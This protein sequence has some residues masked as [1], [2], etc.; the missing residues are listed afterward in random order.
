MNSNLSLNT[1][2]TESGLA[3]TAK[4]LAPVEHGID[5]PAAS[6]GFSLPFDPL[7]VVDAIYARRWIILIAGII[8]GAGLVIAGMKRFSTHHA[9]VAQLI[10]QTPGST[11]RQSDSGDPYQP[12][13]L[14]IPTLMAVMRSAALMEKTTARLDGKFSEGLLKSGLIIT[15]ERNTDIV[16]VSMNSDESPDAAV[17]MLKGYV[18]EVLLLTRDIQQHDAAEANRFLTQQIELADKDLVKV[19]DEL[20]VYGKREQ[21][22]DADKQMDSYLGEIAGFNLKYEA[23]RLDHE[24]VDLKIKSIENELAKVSP[25][26]A[27]LQQ[28]RE[29]L[30]SLQLRYTNEHPSVL[31][32]TDRVK[33]MEATLGSDK[34]RLDAPP[35]QGDGNVSESLYLELVKLRSEKQVLGEQLGKLLAVRDSLSAKLEELPRKSLEYARIKSRKQALETSRNLLAAR[36]RE[37]AM[38]EE[39]AQGSFRLLAMARPQDVII[40][41][42]TK[43]LAM[44]GIGGFAGAAGGLA[45]LFGLLAAKDRRVVTVKDLKRSTGLPVLGSL[46]L[47]NEDQARDWAFHTWTK[48]QP[49]LL[50]PIPGGALIC[51]LITSDDDHS[52]RMPMLLANA[53]AS[54]GMSV[55]VVSRGE[56][57]PTS[58]PLREVV[59]QPESVLRS[60]NET[61]QL[62][63]HLTID[64][65]WQWNLTQRQQWQ[66]TM[67]QWAQARGTVILVQLTKPSQADTLLVAERLPNLL[68]IGQSE[69]QRAEEAATQ[70][71]TYRAAGCRIVG[72]LLDRAPTFRLGLLNKLAAT[73]ACLLLSMATLAHADDVVL[74]PGDAVN[75][76]AAGLPEL[77]RNQVYVGPDGNIT[78]LQAQNFRAAGLTID[79]LRVKLM[80]ELRRY[81]KNLLLVVTPMT[82]QSRKVYVLGKVVRKG[83]INMDRPLTLLEVVAEA[84]GLETGLFQQNT[85][86]LADLGRSFLMRGNQRMPVDMEKLFLRGDMS[87]NVPIKPD[88]Y[89]YF[90]SANSNEI[91]VLGDVTMQ[92]TQG[93]LAHTSV[94]S[95]IAQ[96]GGFTPK[97]YTRRILVVRGSLEK[98][99]TF[100]VN[101]DDIL[102]GREKGFRLQPKDIVYIAD[103]PW[104]RAEE[105]LSFAVNAFLQGAVSGWAG[106]NVGPMIKQAILPSLN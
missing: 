4:E 98:P 65:N 29:E 85:V 64:D 105:L 41:R 89:L 74:G 8:A 104:A 84:G 53:A 77:A 10:K 106:A 86:E 20:L 52:H 33:A 15:P 7:R 61:S 44:A 49:R 3:T 9:A 93:L 81:Y 79:E 39:S 88:D 83:A 43:K 48:L 23:T 55:I 26:A 69:S 16:R 71:D 70:L 62:V 101:M 66:D 91:Y 102:S 18:D 42:P 103:K 40:E 37:A 99:E 35:K 56:G 60:L 76:T 46:A 45:L 32:A 2:T 13:A 78:Y 5:V 73:T 97:A 95:A 82:F 17:T 100:T 68:W 24:T 19:N 63:V 59:Q 28:A 94:H 14:A 54:R 96:A 72:A 47:Q 36:Q 51:G 22:V 50:M 6:A 67:T 21:L 11:I 38:H 1:S 80:T 58:A 92:G 75:I 27:T 90:P 31:E 57:I 12:H 30:A 87:Q 25:A 34:P